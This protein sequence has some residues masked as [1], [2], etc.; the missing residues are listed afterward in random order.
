[1]RV[2]YERISPAWI[3]QLTDW[4]ILSAFSYCTKVL[5]RESLLF[6]EE[7]E[8]ICFFF[9]DGDEDLTKKTL[10]EIQKIYTREYSKRHSN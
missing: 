9:F 3:S 1:M 4:E 10:E 5:K 2:K 6:E 7:F 8:D